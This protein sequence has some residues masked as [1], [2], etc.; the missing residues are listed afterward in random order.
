MDPILF[1]NRKPADA[2]TDGLA[3]FD[4][5]KQTPA[6]PVPTSEDAA[7]RVSPNLSLK[8]RDVLLH[9]CRHR[10][11]GVTDNELIADLTAEGWNVNTPRARR[12]E[13]FRGDWLDEAGERDGSIV[14]RPSA[15]ALDW[16]HHFDRSAEGYVGRE[17]AA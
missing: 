5:P 11:S 16:Y 13:L 14:W 12:V 3:L 1:Q 8:R 15:K 17:D 6:Q 10:P 9:I 7:A 4:S 2:G